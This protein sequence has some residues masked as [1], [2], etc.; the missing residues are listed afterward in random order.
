MLYLCIAL[1]M[2]EVDAL[3][4]AYACRRFRIWRSLAMALGWPV[5]ALVIVFGTAALTSGLPDFDV[6]GLGQRSSKDE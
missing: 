1:V 5:W 3:F 2:W 4:C 6:T